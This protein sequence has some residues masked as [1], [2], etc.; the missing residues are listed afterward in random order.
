MYI[1]IEMKNISELVYINRFQIM[2][3]LLRPKFIVHVLH[4]WRDILIFVDD[5]VDVK[6]S[7]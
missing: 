7:G 1:M 3:M 4:V 6:K 2:S 5:V